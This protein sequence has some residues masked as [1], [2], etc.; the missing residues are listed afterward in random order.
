MSK[1][2]QQ[3]LLLA[4]LLCG[5]AIPSLADHTR[6]WKQS[7]YEE[8]LKGTAKGVAVRS[9]G[10]L[11]LAPK[12]TLV[13]DADASY[14]WS[15]RTD[16]AGAWYAGS[17]SPAK[18]FRFDASGKP[19]AV[20]EST[21]LLAQCI[22][23]DAKGSLYVGTSP[24]GKVY[25]V[26]ANGEKSIF[27]EPK[28]KYI[29]DLAFGADGT[30]YVAT[31]DKGQIYAVAPDGK[32]DIYYASDEAHIKVLDFDGK[33]N[34]LAGTE[35]NGRVLRVGRAGKNAK[36]SATATVEGFVLYETAKREVTSLAVGADGNIY[37]AAIGDKSRATSPGQPT[38]IALPQG[39]T[40][41][42]TPGVQNA[43]VSAPFIAFPQA[44]SSSIYR[45]T[46]EGVPEEIW[47]SREDVVYSLGL[48]SDGR[49]L[50]GTGNNGSLLVIDGR[51]VYA[52]LAKAGAS[53]I[54][55]ISRGSNGKVYL[56]TANPGK[57]FS[58]GPEYEAEGT[59][60]SQ[61]FDAKL[62]SQWGRIEWWGPPATTGVSKNSKDNKEPRLEIYVRS[63]NTEDPGKEWSPWFGPYHTT[64]TPVE[65]PP[66]R[67]LQWRAVI[68]DGR[69]GDGIDWVSV[70]YLP[71]N[72][73]PV[74]DGIAIQDPGVRAQVPLGLTVP[75]NAQLKQPPAPNANPGGITINTANNPAT[76]AKF[77]A[78]PQ[79][80]LQKGYQ[81][82]LWSAHDDNE[83]DLKYA[84]YFRG[85]NQHDWL[86]LKDNLDQKFYS[87]DTTSMPDG[88]YYLK[89]VATDAPSNPRELA[90]KT[91]RESE[92]FEVDNATPTIGKIDASPTGMNADRSQGVSYDFQ[93]TA[94]HG[95][96]S[97]E[98]AQYS[99]DG[100]DWILLRPVS[101]ISDYKTETYSFTVRGLR[102]GEHTIA[103]RAFDR[104]ENVGAAKTTI[105]VAGPGN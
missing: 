75:G 29:W 9:D 1:Q 56:C 64:D 104:F 2:S 34:L 82:V 68:H 10:H 31:G 94:S 78:Q 5:L 53:Q 28:T 71:A 51:G 32:G 77:E 61:S 14:L 85:E 48:N 35:P 101:G 8:F 46:P 24:D 33:G 79:G 44:I 55:G 70:A 13:A 58:L 76:T 91:E 21:D 41:I 52:Q 65:A 88:P 47:T 38:S 18:V 103:V 11:E 22:A 73:A 80:S 60:E 84:V 37:V 87:W 16:A 81:S 20:F 50:A 40:T 83:D 4:L 105:Q 97:I 45:I 49:L 23:F 102:P 92:R 98:R 72:V 42:A 74:I 15:L 43:G 57:V 95:T 86:L 6:R 89:I 67:F 25:K 59:F 7:T 96:N 54:T 90:L 100:G 27:F 30:L 39:T 19:K 3:F 99:V 26:S 66:A 36:K 93:F 69:P 12:F 63:G 17:G 62:F